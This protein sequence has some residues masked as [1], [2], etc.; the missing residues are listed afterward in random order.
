[1]KCPVCKSWTFV[2][3]TRLKPDN[4]KYRRYECANVHR[5]TT[6]ETVVKIIVAKTPK[7][8]GLS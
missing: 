3:E 6:L 7:N 5:F 8:K 1:M 2:L 4:T